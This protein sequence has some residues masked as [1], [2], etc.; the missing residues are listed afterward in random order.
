MVAKKIVKGIRLG[1]FYIRAKVILLFHYDNKLFIESRWFRGGK[2]GTFT[3]LGWQWVVDDYKACKRMRVNQ[4][5]PWPVSARIC[6]I[7]PENIEFHEDDLN[8]FQGIGNYYQAIGKIKIGR[9]TYIASN[10]GIITANH[11]IG[12]LDEHEEAKP[13]S[14]GD[15]C[16][17]GMNS[18]ILPGVSLGNNTTVGAGSVVTKSFPDGNVVI[19]GNPAKVIRKI[20][21]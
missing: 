18:I 2:H 3:A 14:I 7:C 10:V 6:V 4:Y 5:V 8:N 21:F 19:A 9:G 12:N 13:V 20:D 17:I 16:W 1:L 15:N 11:K